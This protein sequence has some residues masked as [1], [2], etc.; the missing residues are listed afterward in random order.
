LSTTAHSGPSCLRLRRTASR[1]LRF[2]RFR[3]TLLPTAFGAVSPT[4]G[5]LCPLMRRQN[6][7][8]YGP[9]IRVPSS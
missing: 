1:S 4:L 2:K 8:K 5:R 9:A 6:A 7:A 3:T